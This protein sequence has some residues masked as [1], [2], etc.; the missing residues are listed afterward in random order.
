MSQDISDLI[1]DAQPIQDILG[2][3]K[4]QLSPDLESVIIPAAYIK[5][6]QSKIL[7]ALNRHENRQAQESLRFQRDTDRQEALDLKKQIDS[8]SKAPACINQ[9]IASLR[10]KEQHLMKE[11]E[12]TR[13]AIA[14]EEKQ[15]AGLPDTIK[16]VKEELVIKIHNVKTLHHS[17][18]C[19]PGS[20]EADQAEIDEVD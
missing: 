20:A 6:H 4:H 5:G 13:P 16:W 15:L 17:I 18:E 12:D 1:Q 19:I 7:E 2:I 14:R 8:L 10:V 11:P 3:I 9:E